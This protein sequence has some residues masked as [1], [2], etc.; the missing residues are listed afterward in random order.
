M[1]NCIRRYQVWQRS[2]PL[3]FAI[4]LAA[5]IGFSPGVW[6]QE[7]V[8]KVGGTGTTLGTMQRLG[9][10]FAQANPGVSVNVLSSLGST[11]GIKA[12]LAG[13]IDL[14]LSARLLSDDE[15]RQGAAALEYGRSPLVLAVPRSVSIT[16][17]TMTQ[18]IDIYAG[19]MNRWPDGTP[20]R[21]LLRPETEVSTIMLKAIS[22]QLRNA[23]TAAE[24]RPGMLFALTDQ[25]ATENLERNAGSIGPAALCQILTAG[26]QLKALSLDGIVPSAA[27]V[28]NGSYRYYY[29]FFMVT[30]PKRS[31]LTDQFIAFVQSEAGKRI[32]TDTGYW[33]PSGNG[34]R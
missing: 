29:R 32:L 22:P 12:V 26:S 34:V 15:R 4:L 24:K 28:A 16:G 14:G 17:I 7:K 21:L 3:T 19:K 23:V 9:T 25:D 10:A 13:A 18:L 1:N 5:C 20:I 8:L 30:G 27:A 11:G 33:M 6:A 2:Y 31:A